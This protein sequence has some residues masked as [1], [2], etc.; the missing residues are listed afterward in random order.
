MSAGTKEENME[1]NI[2]MLFRLSSQYEKRISDLERKVKELE[3]LIQGH[4]L[5]APHEIAWWQ[6]SDYVIKGGLRWGI[7]IS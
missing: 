3:D 6:N 7:N 1:A 5:Y 4:V 2:D